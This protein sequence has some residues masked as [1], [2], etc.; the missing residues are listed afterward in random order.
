MDGS[1][2]KIMPFSR[3]SCWFLPNSCDTNC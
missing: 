1:H 2:P 3:Y